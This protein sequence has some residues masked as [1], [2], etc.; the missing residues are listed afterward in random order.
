MHSQFPS[1]HWIHWIQTLDTLNSNKK[2]HWIH[3]IHWIHWICW[4][5][6][7]YQKIHWIYWTHVWYPDTL[8]KLT[9]RL[10]K[11]F[12]STIN[13]LLILFSGTATGNTMRRWTVG[14][15][16]W[17]FELCRGLWPPSASV[18][19]ASRTKTAAAAATV[20][21]E[22]GRYQTGSRDR[23]GRFETGS[24][25]RIGR[26]PMAFAVVASAWVDLSVGG[27]NF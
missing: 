26:T 21:T 11:I 12:V 9:L 2:I 20:K 25:D 10:R 16:A 17:S 4:T 15:F 8:K 22:I 27:A 1:F 18:S 23:I 13:K 14:W 6:V 19:T 7:W 24:R 3:S 5:H